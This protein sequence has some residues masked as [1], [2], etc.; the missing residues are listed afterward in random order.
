MTDQ[1]SQRVKGILE[2][3]LMQLAMYTWDALHSLKVG[4]SAPL[5]RIKLEGVMQI[6]TTAL[7]DL[8]AETPKEI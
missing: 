5:M 7:K 8:D 4:A 2:M 6:A 3:D 1:P